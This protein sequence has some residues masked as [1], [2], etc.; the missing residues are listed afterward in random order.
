MQ[1]ISRLFA[2][3]CLA[4]FVLFGLGTFNTAQAQWEYARFENMHPDTV[5]LMPDEHF[6]HYQACIVSDFMSNGIVTFELDVYKDYLIDDQQAFNFFGCDTDYLNQCGSI[7]EDDQPREYHANWV[8][9]NEGIGVFTSF[10]MQFNNELPVGAQTSY[11]AGVNGYVL[12]YNNDFQLFNDYLNQ[13]VISTDGIKGDANGDGSVTSADVEIIQEY[14]FAWWDHQDWRYHDGI[15]V[16]RSLMLFSYPTLLDAY[17]INL[18]L[19]NPNDPLVVNLGIGELISATAYGYGGNNVVQ[20]APYTISQVWNELTIST[21]GLAAFVFGNL[22]DGT[23]WQAASWTS[24]GSTTFQLPDGLQNMRIEAV[25]LEGATSI[26]APLEKPMAFSLEQNYP[27]PFNPTTTID[28]NLQSADHVSLKVYDLNGQLVATLADSPMSAGQHSVK[29][30]ANN[31]AS[32]TYIY[33]L[34]A[35]NKTEAKKMILMK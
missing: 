23:H 16:G 14:C 5:Y 32:G 13:V 25:T 12:D 6:H 8:A 22:P 26:E 17:L 19:I 7:I 9:N 18:W 24:N 11:L 3:I 34:T 1:S 10:I 35:G 4:T 28:F 31:L 27:N 29:F 21:D 2:A 20:P 33:E 30:D 15:N